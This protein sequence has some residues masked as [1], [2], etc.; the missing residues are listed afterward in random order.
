M[1]V[2]TGFLIHLMIVSLLLPR[3][4]KMFG[5]LFLILLEGGS[6]PITLTFEKELGVDV[7][8]LPMGRGDD[9]AHSINEN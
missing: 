1:M 8:L 2:I 4:L 3:Q 9:G 5:M 6:I 7:L